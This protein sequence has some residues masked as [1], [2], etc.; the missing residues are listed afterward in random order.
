MC[1]CLGERE[2]LLILLSF[3]SEIIL[4]FP[5]KLSILCIMHKAAQYK[6][7]ACFVKP[8]TTGQCD[9]WKHIRIC[10]LFLLASF[11]IL[12]EQ[13]PLHKAL[14]ILLSRF[15]LGS[16][17]SSFAYHSGLENPDIF[18]LLSILQ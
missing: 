5:Q 14:S 9:K 15:K 16:M 4:E 3:S 2:I 18:L 8:Q 11:P 17:F 7:A 10:L 1:V 6:Q 13:T 12:K